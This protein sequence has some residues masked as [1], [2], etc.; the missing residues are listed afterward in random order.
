M[1]KSVVKGKNVRLGNMDDFTHQEWVLKHVKML[2]Q[3]SLHRARESDGN[4]R[5]FVF[6]NLKS[7]LHKF[8]YRKIF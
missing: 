5:W 3:I 2:Q 7:H 1:F 6:V 4:E 8:V